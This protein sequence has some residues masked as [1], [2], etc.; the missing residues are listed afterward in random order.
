MHGPRPRE[1]GRRRRAARAPPPTSAPDRARA[2]TPGSSGRPASQD[3]RRTTAQEQAS[4]QH[5]IAHC[6]LPL[7]PPR[8]SATERRGLLLNNPHNPSG[9]LWHPEAIL[10]QLSS[11]DVAI[12]DEAFMDFLPQEQQY[13]LISQVQSHENLVVIRSLTKFYSI[14]GLR[15]GYAI[16]HPDRLRR[17][18]NWRD[19]WSVNVLAAAVGMA[20]LGD[21]NF[22]QQTWDWLDCARTQLYDG[23]AQ[24]PGLFPLASAAN[25]LLVR[26]EIPSSQ[27]QQTLLQRHQ[28][29]IRDC[30]S[31]PEL[32]DRYFRVAIR[33]LEENQRLL[34]GLGNW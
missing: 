19:P 10:T 7:F 15:L 22:Q 31:F 16:G 9:R 18:N 3:R 13:S 17:W 6:S 33:S 32:G 29:L 27:L 5:L 4:R 28:I 14:P 1:C 8:Y 20:V 30:L 24:Q 2:R 26:T 11:F 12:V 34:I 25:F 21:R 23:L